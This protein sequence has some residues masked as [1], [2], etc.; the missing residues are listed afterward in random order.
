MADEYNYVRPVFT[1]DT[2]LEIVDARHPVVV[3]QIGKSHS[4]VPNDKK[5]DNGTG[6]FQ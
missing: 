2:K 1:K 3:E 4:F 5:L 6:D